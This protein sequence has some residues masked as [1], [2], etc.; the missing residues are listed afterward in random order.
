[1]SLAGTPQPTPWAP[2]LANAMTAHGR[3]V[4]E[5]SVADSLLEDLTGEDH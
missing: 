4:Y 5:E 2:S 1:M 3:A